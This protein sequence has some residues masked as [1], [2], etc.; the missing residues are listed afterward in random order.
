MVAKQITETRLFLDLARQAAQEQNWQK[1]TYYLQQLPVL[2]TKASFEE[3]EQKIQ[4]QIWQLALIVLTQGDFS[5]KWQIVKLFSLMGTSGIAPLI[6]TL[7]NDT[8]DT[9]TKWFAIRTLGQFKQPRVVIALAQLLQNTQDPDLM[10]IAAK[11][12]AQIGTPAVETL[13]DLAKNPDYRLVAATSLAHIRLSPVLPALLELAADDNAEIRLLAIE[14][15]GSFRDRQVPP[16]LIKALQDTNS[17][18]RKE[19]VIAL[20]FRSDL[21]QELDLVTHLQ[22][23]LYDFNPDVCRQTAIALGKMKNEVAIKALDEAVRSPNTPLILKLDAIDALAWS[24]MSL[25]LDCLQE[26]IKRENNLVCQKII[27]VLGRIK[28]IPLK[29]KAIAILENFW[30]S[31]QHIDVETKKSL[32]M[33]LGALQAVTAQDILEQLAQDETKMVKLYA[34]SSLKK[35]S[36]KK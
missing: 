7:E 26:A 19:A 29:T 33:A 1:V 9:E 36:R 21:A 11:S 4:E 16:V 23:L 27:T 6:S 13:I 14:A 12:L 20:G 22:P 15:L 31:S 25:A 5:E 17:T 30:H 3:T 28:P 32:A 2:A 10:A 8:T 18:I 24:N 34:I 35:L